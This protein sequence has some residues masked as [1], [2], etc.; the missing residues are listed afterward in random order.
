M[1]LK[2]RILAS[3]LS[4]AEVARRAGTPTAHLY[5]LLKGIRRPRFSLAKRIEAATDGLIRWTEFFDGPVPLHMERAAGE[6]APAVLAVDQEAGA[7]PADAPG[8]VLVVPSKE[9]N[10]K[11]HGITAA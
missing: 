9:P 10:R 6:P 11:H 3:G 5:N 7:A 1:D 2:D 8:V 4:V